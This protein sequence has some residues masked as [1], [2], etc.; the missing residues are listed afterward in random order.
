M[1][2]ETEN[3]VSEETSGKQADQSNRKAILYFILLLIILLLSAEGIF[4]WQE[5]K[6]SKEI[7]Y[8]LRDSQKKEILNNTEKFG[9]IES[10][11]QNLDIQQQKQAELLN[12][13]SK[14]E[15]K[16]GEDWSL[17]EVE[18][19]LIIA[20]HQVMI[21]KNIE[22]AIT[23]L[24][25]ADD[26]LKDMDDTGLYQVRQ[27][28]GKDINSLK[29]VHVADISGMAIFLADMIGRVEDMPLKKLSVQGQDE[30]ADN[31]NL[32]E[33]Q[34]DW[35]GT[36]KK[37][38]AKIWQDLKSMVVIKHR[39]QVNQVLLV[40]EQEYYLYQNLR[41][42]LANARY[43]ILRRDTENMLASIL[44]IK[45]WINTY[46]DTGHTSTSNLLETLDQMQKIELSPELPDITSSLETLKAYR[47]TIDDNFNH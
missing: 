11:L 1:N 12:N 19:L 17:A 34:A 2:T 35:P 45:E 38:I 33:E 13:F 7:I 29:S 44:L 46:F 42:E 18:H 47:H 20:L 39:D 26:R 28:I 10:R 30:Q 21:E 15:R 27:Q 41:L 9:E 40:P 31:N 14:P 4:F 43:A 23:A 25:S 36:L 16:T 3:N 5:I 37:L 6:A 8:G 32:S 24:Q 22:T